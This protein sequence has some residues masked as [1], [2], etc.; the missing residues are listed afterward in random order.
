MQDD[1]RGFDCRVNGKYNR[2]QV[3]QEWIIRQTIAG[4]LIE[5]IAIT[6]KVQMGIKGKTSFVMMIVG[7]FSLTLGSGILIL[8]I[9]QRIFDSVAY[10][11][12]ISS[13][14]ILAIAI[15]SLLLKLNT[16]R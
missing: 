5:A 3:Q 10:Y 15:G 4:T 12:W 8:S 14:S 1:F 6:G 13:L 7:V 11:G 16:R 9:A 2:F